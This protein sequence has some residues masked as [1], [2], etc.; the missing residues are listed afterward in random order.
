MMYYIEPT[1][2]FV[3]VGNGKLQQASGSYERR[4]SDLD[5]IYADQKSFVRALETSGS[6][7]VYRVTEQR[8]LA[9]HGDLIFGVT[10][11]EPGRICDEY[12]LTRGHI[13]SI[14]NRPETYIGQ[15]G[16]GVML[17]E[18]PHGDIRTLEIKPSEI[19]YV[20]A[21]WIHRSI[22]VGNDPLVMSF[23]YPS[24]SGQNYDVIERSGGMKRRIV[25][26]GTG[27]KSIPN[28]NYRQ[29]TQEEISALLDNADRN[30][31]EYIQRN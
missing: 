19:C 8:P 12:Y 28:K 4:L 6:D 14:T 3:D 17:L 31:N 18:S 13:H 2:H 11:M 29:R 15:A 5:G 20:P 10:Y 1:H 24:D 16:S 23:C 9:S 21:F 22:N 7:V 27:W 25:A 26:D 30:I